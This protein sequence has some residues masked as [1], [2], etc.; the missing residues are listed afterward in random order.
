[1]NPVITAALYRK[2]KA[3][4]SLTNSELIDLIDGLTPVTAFLSHAGPEFHFCWREISLLLRDLK[5]FH[6]A[7]KESRRI[8]EHP[9]L[10]TDQLQVRLS[11]D[12]LRS[13]KVLG[14]VRYAWRK[15]DGEK[16]FLMVSDGASREL[17][18]IE[19]QTAVWYGSFCGTEQQRFDAAQPGDVFKYK[20][21]TYRRLTPLEYLPLYVYGKVYK[22]RPT[23]GA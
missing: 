20:R 5:G 16:N 15:A 12:D 23:Q 21:T 9:E 17:Y 8:R 6:S 4:E 10:R 19:G 14:G 22:F 11:K 13:F 1:M 18:H 2:Q 3:A 7:R